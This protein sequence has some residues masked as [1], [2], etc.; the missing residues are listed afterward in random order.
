MFLIHTAY[1]W[2][3]NLCF[4][5]KMFIKNLQKKDYTITTHAGETDKVFCSNRFI[6][7]YMI[8]AFIH[9][10]IT[11]Y[12]SVAPK[13]LHGQMSKWAKADLRTPISQVLLLILS[14]IRPTFG[15]PIAWEWASCRASSAVVKSA[16]IMV[17]PNTH[18]SSSSWA[19]A[20][21][22]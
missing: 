20:P 15:A 4:Y 8:H 2:K 21:C 12:A 14:K 3:C 7:E 6:V 5:F 13:Q 11:N 16:P 1:Q 10:C 17:T 19:L 9:T 22:G 18:R